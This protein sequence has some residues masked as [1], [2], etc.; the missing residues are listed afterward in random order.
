ME[1]AHADVDMRRAL[2]PLAGLAS[3]HGCAIIFMIHLNKNKGG[4]LSF[5]DRIIGSVGSVNAARSVLGMAPHPENEGEIVLA[6]VKHNYSAA[7]KSL[8]FRLEEVSFLTTRGE[9]LTTTKMV[10]TGET[11]VTADD[12]VAAKERSNPKLSAAIAFV[13]EQ[14]ANGPAPSALF[15]AAYAEAGHSDG[16][17]TQAKK[18]LGVVSK[19]HEGTWLVGLEGDF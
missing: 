12:L 13:E 8:V 6:H 5:R 17:I 4:A 2:S 1:N 10:K 19:R 11:E 14:L 7:Q 16:M 3:K 15:N 9:P 18:L